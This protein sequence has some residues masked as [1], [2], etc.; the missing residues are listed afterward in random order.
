MITFHPERC[1]GC[2]LCVDNCHEDSLALVEG[3]VEID[4]TLCDICA[5]CIAICPRQAIS[6]DGA[7]PVAFDR[8]RLPSTEQLLELFRERRSIRAYQKTRLEKA[9]LEEIAASGVYAPTHNHVFK[10]IIIDDPTLIAELSAAIL[11]IND[12]IYRLIYQHH[13][14]DCL[15]NLL[16]YG[17]E[18]RK[19]RPKL[20]K[21]YRRGS[22]FAST[23]AAIILV[24]GRKNV[25][26][27]EASAQY[28]LA[29][30]MYFAQIQ[31]LGACLWGN[32]PIFL[33]KQ[34]PIRRRLG[35]TKQERIYG[36]L[37]VGYPAI[38]FSNKV[39]GKS[40][41]IQ[42]NGAGCRE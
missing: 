2:G 9:L 35:I 42:W 14:V 26:L 29:N 32:A 16:G 13:L 7:P 23:P 31:G 41:P 24:V 1:S 17:D 6:W 40:L 15:A 10:A 20:E 8:S 39:N 25:A 19:A 30:M 11:S 37:C 18:F 12:R 28:A 38:K 34:R 3:A 33:D 4:R 5:Q 22:A 21:A 27:A 36:A